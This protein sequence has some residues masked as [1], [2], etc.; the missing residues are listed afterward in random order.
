M[1]L[2]SSGRP[3][4]GLDPG[5]FL[6]PGE[7]S[8]G[9]RYRHPGR[10]RQWL[11]GRALAK[12][13]LVELLNSH[14]G[15]TWSPRDIVVERSEQGAPLARTASGR[16]LGVSLSISHHQEL[17]LCALCPEDA[18]H[19]GVDL[20]RIE[21]RSPA[22]LEDYYTPA[23]RRLIAAQEGL[24]AEQATTVLWCLKEAGLKALGTGLKV[25]PTRIETHEL[26]P[27]P[28]GEWNPARV[29][30]PGMERVLAWWRVRD[31]LAMAMVLGAP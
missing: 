15:R 1:I 4:P 17:A 21:P 29:S 20:E 5:L 26:E 31:D 19:L 2:W 9:E 23:E 16:P 22:F 6:L 3:G 12:Q 28:P 8:Q 7:R 18:G 24:S 10:H 11:L 30:L 13:L 27:G 25:N 14:N